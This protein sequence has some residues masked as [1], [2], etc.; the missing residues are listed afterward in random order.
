VGVVGGGGERQRPKIEEVGATASPTAAEAPPRPRA[1]SGWRAGM[2]A[3]SDCRMKT[4]GRRSCGQSHMSEEDNRDCGQYNYLGIP[5]RLGVF[6]K[7]NLESKSIYT[8][9]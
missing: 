8:W 5:S 1:A 4:R 6:F 9:F 3:R 2:E 7:I